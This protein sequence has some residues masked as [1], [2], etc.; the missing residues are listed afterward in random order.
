MYLR[1]VISGNASPL[2]E[3]PADPLRVFVVAH[4]DGLRNAA[5]LLAGSR[6]V[7]LV[8]TIYDRLRNDTSRIARKTWHAIRDLL[9]ILT[10]EHVHDETR[11]EA[12]FFAN[13][14]PMDPVVE[15]VCLL[16]DGLR[17]ALEQ[18]LANEPEAWRLHQVA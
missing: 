18:A 2:R 17:A 4:L 5:G 16:T 11:P 8:E 6:G 14:D 12:S 9:G 10:L 1:P 7:R 3:D 15:E 13:I